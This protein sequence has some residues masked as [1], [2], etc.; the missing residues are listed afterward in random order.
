MGELRKLWSDWW[1]PAACV[2]W[3]CFVWAVAGPLAAILGSIGMLYIC[4]VIAWE[5]GSRKRAITTGERA[6]DA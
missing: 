1:A 3:H 5:I 6:D 2:G 4:F